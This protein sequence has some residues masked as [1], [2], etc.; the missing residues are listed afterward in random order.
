MTGAEKITVLQEARRSFEQWR[1]TLSAMAKPSARSLLAV[2]SISQQLRMADEVLRSVRTGQQPEELLEEL[3]EELAH[4]RRA[5]QELHNWLASLEITLQIQ[6]A[7][8]HRR[9]DH[10]RAVQTWS[11]LTRQIA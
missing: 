1:K 10:L 11:E 2:R 6:R 5:L 8:I 3:K 9:K 4:Y 7:Q